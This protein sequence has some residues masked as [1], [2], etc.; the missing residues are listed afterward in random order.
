MPL[1]KNKVLTGSQF[2]AS[3]DANGFFLMKA[4]PD[5]IQV[6]IN[7]ILFHTT[8]SCSF[9][10]SIVD[11]DDSDNEVLLLS[12]SG[13]DLLWQPVRLPTENKFNWPLK[14]QTTGMTGDGWLTIDYDFAATEG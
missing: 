14:F 7:S 1:F 9:T 12:G 5:S 11:P 4:G 8:A 3:S 6:D 10:I 13:T 2:T